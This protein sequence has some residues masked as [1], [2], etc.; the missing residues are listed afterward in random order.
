MISLNHELI[1][2]LIEITGR[3]VRKAALENAIDQ[4]NLSRFLKGDVKRVGSVKIAKL[5]DYLGLTIDGKLKD[6]VH[7]WF[8]ASMFPRDLEQLSVVIQTLLPGG[9][10]LIPIRSNMLSSVRLYALAPIKFLSVRILLSI[11]TLSKKRLMSIR[12]G[13]EKERVPHLSDFG[14][15]SMWYR[16]NF[17]EEEPSECYIRL[18]SPIFEKIQ[19]P[20]LS[21][22]ELDEIL[23]FPSISNS[24]IWTRERLIQELDSKGISY[25]DAAKRLGLS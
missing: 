8:I 14:R 15:G 6:G 12:G 3:S 21:I 2:D 10:I 9:V 7:R 16:G 18:D 24:V 13:E 5:I 22:S 20:D 4:P 25:E 17:N 19:Q 11:D 1:N 23:G